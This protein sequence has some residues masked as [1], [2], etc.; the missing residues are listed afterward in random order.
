MNANGLSLSL[1][2][3]SLLGASCFVPPSWA[4]Q[5]RTLEKALHDE[6]DKLSVVYTWARPGIKLTKE[7]Y[8]DLAKVSKMVPGKT[9]QQVRLVLLLM[10]LL[11]EGVRWEIFKHV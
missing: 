6:H 2:G 10:L 8:I 5:V 3:P 11:A 9:P 7:D 1:L 4:A